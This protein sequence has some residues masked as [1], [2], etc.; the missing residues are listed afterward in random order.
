MHIHR[1]QNLRHRP[2]GLNASSKSHLEMLPASP[3]ARGRNRLPKT[4]NHSIRK[5]LG[6]VQV[7]H[8]R[9]RCQGCTEGCSLLPELTTCCCAW[10]R[11][12]GMSPP[13][14]PKTCSDRRGSPLLFGK[15]QCPHPDAPR[16]WGTSAVGATSLSPQPRAELL[17]L[18]GGTRGTS[19]FPL[20]SL[21]SRRVLFPHHS[22]SS[23]GQRSGCPK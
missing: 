22:L 4:L 17:L 23:F 3:S 15:G 12:G 9:G 2:R 16:N 14:A 19:A 11:R 20:L 5:E 8:I 18:A 13:R 6:A 7:H 10:L 1:K 21:D